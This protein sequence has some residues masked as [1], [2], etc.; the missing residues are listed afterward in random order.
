M[1][2]EELIARKERHITDIRGQSIEIGV[3]WG[4]KSKL[5]WPA[6]TG[7]IPVATDCVTDCV[8]APFNEIALS[9]E[10]IA[11]RLFIYMDLLTKQARWQSE[12]LMADPHNDAGFQ[13]ALKSLDEMVATVNRIT[14]V[15]ERL[16]D[17]VAGEKDAVLNALRQERLATLADIDRQRID[18]LTYL[19]RERTAAIDEF[20]IHAVLIDNDFGHSHQ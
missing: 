1:I 13:L 20:L 16:P 15:V 2:H 19:T 10:D 7:Q 8:Q 11:F 14:P 17:L 9:V 3:E 18:T 5:G 4:F 6:C 12:L